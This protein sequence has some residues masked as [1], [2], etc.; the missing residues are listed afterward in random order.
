MVPDVIRAEHERAPVPCLHRR[1]V[2]RQHV[3]VVGAI[4]MR[5]RVV[6][7]VGE[8]AIV[9]IDAIDGQPQQRRLARAD[10]ANAQ[11]LAELV[12]LLDLHLVAL[13]GT[14]IDRT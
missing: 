5:V 4:V 1:G 2:I 13:H 6:G 12:V 8:R 10:A 14:Q 11:R 7:I 9:G 3:E